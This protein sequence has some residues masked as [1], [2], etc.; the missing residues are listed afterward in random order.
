VSFA[1]LMA[2]LFRWDITPTRKIWRL[3]LPYS[4]MKQIDWKTILKRNGFEPSVR[5]VINCD[6]DGTI[7]REVCYSREE[8]INAVPVPEMV[9]FL[10]SAYN[11]REYLPQI[12]IYTARR[13]K[14]ARET[15]EW[16]EKNNLPF[17]ISFRKKSGEVYID[18]KA[19]NSRDIIKHIKGHKML[20]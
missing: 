18:D 10:W 5:M 13:T 8:C 16:L 14:F 3:A 9:E 17:P 6:L 11:D 19:I 4:F 2:G 1:I 15:I 12:I 7:C 20:H